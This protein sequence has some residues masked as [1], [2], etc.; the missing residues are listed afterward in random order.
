MKGV[1][2][3]QTILYNYVW[4]DAGVVYRSGLE[5]RRSASYRGF[6]SLSVRHFGQR[7]LRKSNK[8][9]ARS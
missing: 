8:F 9:Y 3:P 2:F 6:E 1:I 7:A 5:N 4:T